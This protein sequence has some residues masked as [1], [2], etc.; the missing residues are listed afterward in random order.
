[1]NLIF[2]IIEYLEET[3]QIIVKFCRQNAPKP[4][5]TYPPVAIDCLNLD[6]Y[7]YNQFVVS[8]MRYGV[9]II[10]QQ[11][12]E[13]FTLLENTPS[14]IIESTEIKQQLNRVISL[15]TDELTTTT[16]RMNKITLD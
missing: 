16:Y 15:S 6:L 11:E 10:L 3:D 1:M 2:K 5:D 7:D 13:E 8:L 9:D 12:S 4:I 14:E